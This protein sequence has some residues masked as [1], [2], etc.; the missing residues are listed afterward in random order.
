MLA[1]AMGVMV[2]MRNA[3]ALTPTPAWVAGRFCVIAPTRR[4]WCVQGERSW[5]MACA[6]VCALGQLEARYRRMRRVLRV[7]TFSDAKEKLGK[8]YSESVDTFGRKTV[9][10]VSSQGGLTKVKSKGVSIIFDRNEKMQSVVHKSST[11]AN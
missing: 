6:K 7:T 8:P 5:L 1:A 4:C 3:V 11:E 9:I 2:G 10:W